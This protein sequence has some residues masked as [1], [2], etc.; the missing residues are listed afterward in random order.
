MISGPVLVNK[1]ET[2]WAE[3]VPGACELSFLGNSTEGGTMAL[4]TSITFGVSG[5]SVGSEGLLLQEKNRTDAI[6]NA[7]KRLNSFKVYL[8]FGSLLSH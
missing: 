8:V 3:H 7:E 4:G 2:N 5:S 1:A 6:N